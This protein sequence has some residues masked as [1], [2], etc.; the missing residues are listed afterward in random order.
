MEKETLLTASQMI[1]AARRLQ[2]A[3]RLQRALGMLDAAHD[4]YPLDPLVLARKSSLEYTTGDK[5]RA[6]TSLSKAIG[7][8]SGEEGAQILLAKECLK[9][10]KYDLLEPALAILGKSHATFAAV[11]RAKAAFLQGRR[12][13]CVHLLRPVLQEDTARAA[14]ALYLAA[15]ADNDP[16]IDLMKAS[17]SPDEMKNIADKAAKL[18]RDPR[19]SISDDVNIRTS[20]VMRGSIFKGAGPMNR[21]TMQALGDPRLKNYDRL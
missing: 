21:S 2:A 12:T 9:Q 5:A 3:G 11:C 14:R 16:V 20:H 1:A 19:L 10:D 7:L 4:Q 6:A 8:R 17:L 13:D 18:K 15:A